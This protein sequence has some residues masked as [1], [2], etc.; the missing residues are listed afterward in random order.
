MHPPSYSF[1]SGSGVHEG[2]L[3][4]FRAVN[5]SIS[6]LL[7]SLKSDGPERPLIITGH[8]LV[9]STIRKQVTIGG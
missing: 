5:D 3:N 2:F 8:S 9:G 6:N 1:L 7:A 4:Y